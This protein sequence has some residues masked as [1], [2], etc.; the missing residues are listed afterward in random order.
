MEE[1]RMAKE[2]GTFD[3]AKTF[4]LSKNG[5]LFMLINESHLAKPNSG[6]EKPRK[7]FDAT[8]RSGCSTKNVS[9]TSK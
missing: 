5:E 9:K 2:N 8:A 7:T 6:F 3:V 4:H 1:I